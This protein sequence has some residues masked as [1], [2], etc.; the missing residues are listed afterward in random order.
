MANYN[1]QQINQAPAFM[2]V[3]GEEKLIKR[4]A[5][6]SGYLYF[7]TDSGKIYLD[8][9]KENKI[10]MGGGGTSLF[11]TDEAKVEAKP[12]EIYLLTLSAINDASNIKVN[13]L[14]IN[15]ANGCFYKV[16]SINTAS[17]KVSCNLL[18]VSGTG[19]GGGSSGGGSAELEN[20]SVEISGI[21]RRDL[22]VYGE[23]AYITI[24]P[25]AKLDAS[26]DITF[27]IIGANDKKE[28]TIE[29]VPSGYM[30]SYDIGSMLFEGLNDIKIHTYRFQKKSSYDLKN[31]V[32]F[33]IHLILYYYSLFQ[34]IY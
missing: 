19:S 16:K 13:D 3:F 31:Q 14:I 4:A 26:V 25:T 28:H 23:P 32:L 9:D 7:A 6:T 22:F 27:E 30:D 17:D 33:L 20:L 12:G 10:L 2:P 18:A 24:T 29:A 5:Q 1:N 15:E 11:Y 21:S 34:L 8:T